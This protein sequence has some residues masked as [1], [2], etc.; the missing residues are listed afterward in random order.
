M[1]YSE[2]TNSGKP[3]PRSPWNKGEAGR[4]ET[5]APTRPRLVHSGKAADRT[6]RA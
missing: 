6:A 2:P 1:T 3:P 4:A 5:A